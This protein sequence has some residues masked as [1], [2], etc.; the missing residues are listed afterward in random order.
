MIAA[1]AKGYQGVC[2]LRCREP[3]PVSARV[4][5]FQDELE[6]GKTNVPHTFI[7]RC[8]LCGHEDVYLVTAVEKFD[9][10]PRKRIG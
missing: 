9:G 1:L 8:K 3:V 6:N 5:S 10:E 4:T 7:A 2:C